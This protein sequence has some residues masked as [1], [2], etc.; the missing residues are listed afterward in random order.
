M[1]DENKEESHVG[2]GA[3]RK[4]REEG[5]KEA[6]REGMGGGNTRTLYARDFAGQA[7]R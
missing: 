4:S 6:S 5:E 3:G 2:K 7:H 1:Q